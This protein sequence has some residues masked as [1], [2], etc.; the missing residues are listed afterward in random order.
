MR[1]WFVCLFVGLL[2]ACA[3]HAQEYTG[4]TGMIHVPTAEMAPE[5]NVRIGASFL[6]REFL[7]E[8]L[9]NFCFIAV[10]RRS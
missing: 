6:N 2:L 8:N 9:N 7:P 1:R 4:I 5:G 3:L 10:P